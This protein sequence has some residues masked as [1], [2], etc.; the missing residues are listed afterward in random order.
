ML[1][2]ATASDWLLAPGGVSLHFEVKPALFKALV[3]R[4]QQQFV[5][6]VVARTSTLTVP[7]EV[8]QIGPR[9]SDAACAD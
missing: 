4:P 3:E 2:G 8:F 9:R 1:V 5:L 6:E 7:M